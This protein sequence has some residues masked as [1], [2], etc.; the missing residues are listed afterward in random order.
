M[1]GLCIDYPRRS[2]TDGRYGRI[3]DFSKLCDVE[4]VTEA[5]EKVVV[6][7]RKVYSLDKVY[8][9]KSTA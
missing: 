4:L 1:L 9:L 6:L 8:S 5:S 2:P 7:Q 3:G